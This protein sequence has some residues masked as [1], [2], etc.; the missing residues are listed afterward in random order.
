MWSHLAAGAVA[1]G[2]A[3]A[4]PSYTL[5]RPKPGSTCDD[6]GDRERRRSRDASLGAGPV[7]VTGHSAGGHLSGP[8]GLPPPDVLNPCQ[9][10]SSGSC[11]SRRLPIW[12]PISLTAMN[13]DLRLD[14]GSEIA[15]ESPARLSL[16]PAVESHVWVGR[17]GKTGFSLASSD[18]CPEAWSC[19][20]TP[21]S[22]RHQK[23]LTSLTD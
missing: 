23:T 16:R 19:P 6:P 7:V 20:W 13:A 18:S 9:P 14:P 11:R 5:T 22:G 10:S 1:H 15:V 17:Q 12:S 8:D 3:C 21:E 2:W 4:I